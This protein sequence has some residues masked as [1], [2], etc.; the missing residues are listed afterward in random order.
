MKGR[1]K[2]CPGCFR[3]LGPVL[4]EVR[5]GPKTNSVFD[6][7]LFSRVSKGSNEAMIEIQT[8]GTITV[9]IK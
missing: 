7:C 4:R 6:A 1:P 3:V 9:S 5:S 2:A 8:Y